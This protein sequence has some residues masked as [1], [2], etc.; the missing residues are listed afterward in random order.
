M[1]HISTIIYLRIKEKKKEY[2]RL[3]KPRLLL[4]KVYALVNPRA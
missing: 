3:I 2:K 1:V 4:L